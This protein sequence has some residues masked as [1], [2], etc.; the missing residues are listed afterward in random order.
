[1]AITRRKCRCGL[2]ETEKKRAL[3][4]VSAQPR[5]CKTI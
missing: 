3:G 2:L 5:D 1:M 4:L